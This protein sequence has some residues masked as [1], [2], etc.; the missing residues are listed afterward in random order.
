MK[1]DLRARVLAEFRGYAEP[2]PERMA[3]AVGE[4]V[5]GVVGK[6]Q[7]REQ[8]DEV[9]LR[10]AWRS[11][12]GD[13]LANHS[14]PCKYQDGVLVVRASQSAVLYELDRVWKRKILGELRKRFP[15]IRLNQVRF[16]A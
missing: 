7:V 15:G 12:V 16:V 3:R 2:R 5:R 14:E 4:M 1:A 11:I 6:W 10:R 9:E 8:W 13:F